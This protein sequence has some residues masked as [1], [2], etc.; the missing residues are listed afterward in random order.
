M[1]CFKFVDLIGEQESFFIEPEADLDKVELD[2]ELDF[3]RVEED[4]Y[5]LFS[6]GFF[7]WTLG[8]DSLL[9][10]AVENEVFKVP[11]GEFCGV[12]ED[13]GFFRGVARVTFEGVADER[14]GRDLLEDELDLSPILVVDLLE[15]LG[16]EYLAVLP[17]CEEEEDVPVVD[18]LILR[19]LD[20]EWP[21]TRGTIAERLFLLDDGLEFWVDLEDFSFVEWLGDEG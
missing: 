10:L 11:E 2:F 3:S 15:K 20:P 19:L 5:T 16:F 4:E 12:R 21:G 18:P 8:L 1:E 9:G 13:P 14:L 6:M 17:A 7:R